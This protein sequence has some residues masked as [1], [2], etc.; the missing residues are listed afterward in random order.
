M[1]KRIFTI[2]FV[3]II[4][5]VYPLLAFAESQEDFLTDLANGLKARW[6]ISDG[7]TD[8]ELWDMGLRAS[9]IEAELEYIAKYKDASFDNEK[10]SQLAQLYLQGVTL[11][12]KAI[13]YYNDYP[14]VFNNVW[15]TGYMMR[16]YAI[17]GLHDYYGL[18]IREDSLQEFK[19]YIV[20][21]EQPK[22]ATI[23]E[24]GR[25][26]EE[27]HVLDLESI[28]M[29]PFSDEYTKIEVKVRNVSDKKIQDM[30]LK[31]N[32][33][34]D[35]GDILSNTSAYNDGILNAGQATTVSCTFQTENATTVEF[36]GISYTKETGEYV[37]NTVEGFDSVSIDD[38]LHTEEV[39][40]E[41]DTINQS[42]IQISETDSIEQPK[43]QTPQTEPIIQPESQTFETV[44][45][46]AKSD[47]DVE[48][49]AIEQAIDNRVSGNYTN[50]TVDRISVND[51]LGTENNR[52][53]WVVL[54]Y[55]TWDVR[56]SA[57]TSEKMLRMYSDDLAASLANEFNNIQEIACFWEVPY[58]TSNTSKWAYERSGDRMYLT[59]NVL[60]W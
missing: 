14:I 54:V 6:E 36:M 46:P 11:Q 19:D 39:T 56:N 38:Y 48:K 45:E 23:T 40:P 9:Y 10:F 47:R 29:Y 1:M 51:D 55:L 35:N 41:T 57:D 34:D 12:E 30:S 58:L 17:V 8:E 43:T 3:C 44:A 15:S 25:A 26:T 59:D 21:I 18:D 52:N 37:D 5:M 32:V 49:G 20:G 60:G 24:Y 53:D 16:A 7:A 27:E 4:I 31:F 2:G 50:T 22:T 13:A 28:S 42:E 33:L